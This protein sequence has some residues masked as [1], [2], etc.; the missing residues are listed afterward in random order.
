[1]RGSRLLIAR[2]ELRHFVQKLRRPL[3]RD[4]VAAS[5]GT[6]S[7]CSG[8][9]VPQG[10]HIEALAHRPLR[11]PLP[12]PPSIQQAVLTVQQIQMA[13]YKE[14]LTQLGLDIEN[15]EEAV[16]SPLEDGMLYQS[17]WRHV[18]QW[19]ALDCDD[20]VADGHNTGYRAWNSSRCS[21]RGSDAT[22]PNDPARK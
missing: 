5:Q 17:R 16:E 8:H 18:L 11:S 21:W 15:L 10:H 12:S 20:C 9:V 13:N 22:R 3:F 14:V 2:K 7:G 6:S 4:L 1:M 19:R